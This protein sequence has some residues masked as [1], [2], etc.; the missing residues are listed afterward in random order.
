MDK[1]QRNLKQK[2]KILLILLLIFVAIF[3]TLTIIKMGKL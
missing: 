1:Q 3:F 2:N